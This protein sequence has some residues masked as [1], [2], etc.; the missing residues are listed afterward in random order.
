MGNRRQ[1]HQ[2]AVTLPSQLVGDSRSRRTRQHRNMSVTFKCTQAGTAVVPTVL[3]YYH[4]CANHTA[5]VDSLTQS[6]SGRTERVI[7]VL[8]LGS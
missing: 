8:A 5:I 1:G 3:I 4:D 7:E 2:N 6:L